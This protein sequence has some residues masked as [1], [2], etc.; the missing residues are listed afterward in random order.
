MQNIC[1]GLDGWVNKTEKICEINIEK[2][3]NHDNRIGKL[4]T[5][6]EWIETWIHDIDKKIIAMKKSGNDAL[7][8][9]MNSKFEELKKLFATVENFDLLKDW[10]EVVEKSSVEHGWK[11]N[12]L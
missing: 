8:N 9:S 12:R 1:D 4:E 10:V 11:I 7:E 3:D 2:I 5:E 6:V